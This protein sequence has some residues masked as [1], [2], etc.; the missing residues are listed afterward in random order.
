MISALQSQ[1]VDDRSQINLIG[2]TI[3]E[4]QAGKSAGKG[5]MRKSSDA[6]RVIDVNCHQQMPTNPTVR[7]EEKC[8]SCTRGLPSVL[9]A[10]KMACLN[11]HPSPVPYRSQLIDQPEMI[12][13]VQQMTAAL[14]EK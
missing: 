8:V 3:D 4:L 9:A 11:Y 5:K 1:D 10:F 2:F 7:L 12:R 13:L 14:A 6:D